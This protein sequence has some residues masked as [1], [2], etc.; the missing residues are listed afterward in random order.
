MSPIRSSHLSGLSPCDNLHRI[1]SAHASPLQPG[2]YHT[3]GVSGSS[4]HLF[5]RSHK[6]GLRFW[7]GMEVLQCGYPPRSTS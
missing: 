6:E 3:Y 5:E 1:G 7:L 2:K 4:N